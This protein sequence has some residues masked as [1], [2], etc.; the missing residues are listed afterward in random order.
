MV[1]VALQR[2]AAE[3]LQDARNSATVVFVPLPDV[4]P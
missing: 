2:Y 3:R 1:S 4:G